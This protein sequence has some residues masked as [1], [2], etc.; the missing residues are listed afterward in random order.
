ML[1]GVQRLIGRRASLRALMVFALFC[2]SFSVGNPFVWVFI[3]CGSR[4]GDFL[5]ILGF[6]EVLPRATVLGRGI[7]GF[8]PR[9]LNLKLFGN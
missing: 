2:L 6:R 3:S 8:F 9:I 4:L 5:G 7:F 1:A